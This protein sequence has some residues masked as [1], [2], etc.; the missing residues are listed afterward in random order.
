M[1]LPLTALL[2]WVFGKN[3]GHISPWKYLYSTL[4]Y[5]A[6]IPGIFAVTLSVFMFLFEKNGSILDANVY[7]QV[8]PIVS[9]FL[10]LYLIKKN[11]DFDFIPGFGKIGTLV[12]ILTALI[13]LFWIL[14]RTRIFVISFLP[15]QYFA[16]LFIAILVMLRVGMKK[17]LA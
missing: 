12:M 13:A 11:V 16:I 4:V 17:M 14:E 2:A 9:M 8:L 7:T 3:E 10:T 1:A 6:C 15:I 5:L